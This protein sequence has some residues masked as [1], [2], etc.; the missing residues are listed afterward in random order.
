MNRRQFLSFAAAGF[1]GWLLSPSSG[2][3]FPLPMEIKEFDAQ[4]Q[5]IAKLKSFAQDELAIQ[6]KE[7]FYTEWEEKESFNQY[8]Y[9]SL[10]DKIQIPDG[11]PPYMHFGTDVEKATK[12]KAELDEKGY[13]TLLYQTAGT[14]AAHLTRILL[15]YPFESLAFV[16][17]HEAFHVNLDKVKK[18]I[19]YEIEEAFCDVVGNCGAIL[20]AQNAGAGILETAKAEHHKN[21]NEQIYKCILHHKQLIMVSAAADFPQIYKNCEEAL[22]KLLPVGNDFFKN[23]YVYPINNAF[24]IRNYYYT[25]HYFSLARL[26]NKKRNLRDAIQFVSDLPSDIKDAEKALWDFNNS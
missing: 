2:W 21:L 16:V 3:S 19:P 11:L 5:L 1:G 24:F 8:L 15:S 25:E 10:A 18:N 17:L 20:F 6:L 26:V 14:S 13:H 4:Y 12:K 9:V 22:K 23:R 7:K